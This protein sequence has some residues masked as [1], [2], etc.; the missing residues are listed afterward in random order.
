MEDA[1][2]RSLSGGANQSGLRDYNER[3]LLSMLQR[4]GPMPGSDLAR[5]A[6]LSP[7]T[8]SVILRKLEAD[9]LLERGKPVRG[10]VGKPSVPMTLA[11]NG[12]L[13][14]GANIGRRGATIVLMD[15]T[16]N[17]RAS[18]RLSYD[19]P[20]PRVVFDFLES[21]Y[22]ELAST[23]KASLLPRLAGFGIAM[24]SQLWNWHEMI[25]AP[26]GEF[27][28]WKDISFPEQIAK[29]TDLPVFTVNDATAACR[30]EHIYGR[31]KAYRDYAYF[32]LAAFIGGGIVLNHSVVEGHQ[33]NAG[34]LGSLRSSA[35][36]GS[37]R[38][39]IDL[40]SINLLETRLRDAG[41]NPVSLSNFENW[42]RYKQHVDPWLRQ[43]AHELAKASLST[44]SVIDFEAILIDG[45][46]PLAVKTELVAQTRAELSKQDTRGLIV[47]QVVAGDVGGTARERGAACSPIL[48]QYFLD[49]NAGLSDRA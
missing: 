22:L 33:G 29:F 15:F 4:N 39:L 35:A 36:D 19:Y 21:G 14:L 30:A 2:V 28:Q 24:P 11:P 1:K 23:L 7:Q 3:L 5:T 31:G 20:T 44:C 34:S 9:G 17:I 26:A 18:T 41:I 45:V 49:T 46:L 10:K 27:A 37:S 16:G 48:S 47:P 6:G 13:S 40:A 25:G 8:I 42:A 38:Q 32:F 43:T 12:V